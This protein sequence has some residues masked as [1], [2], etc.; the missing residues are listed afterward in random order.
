MPGDRYPHKLIKPHRGR[1]RKSWSKVVDDL[2]SS[3]GLNT[4][5]CIKDN[6]SGDVV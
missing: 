5:E 6:Q 3:L 4:V 2:F 1:Q